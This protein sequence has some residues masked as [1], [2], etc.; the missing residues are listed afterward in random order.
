MGLLGFLKKQMCRAEKRQTENGDNL[1]GQSPISAE[2]YEAK[3]QAEED[4]WER[5]YDLSTVAGINAIPIPKEKVDSSGTGSVT[6]QIDYY[7][8]MKA[9]R[10]QST[11]E[12]ELALAC[13]RKAN[14]LMPMCAV[15][16]Y[17]KDR[18]MRLP[19]YLRKL[20]RFDEARFEEA[21]IEAM[22]PNGSEMSLADQM[23]NKKNLEN[24][25]QGTDLV[26]V[27]WVDGCCE[28][29]GKY[30]GRIF[31][32]TGADTRFP[33]FPNDFCEKCGLSYFPFFEG[34]SEP[35]YCKKRGAALIREMNKPFVDTR[36]PEDVREYREVLARIKSKESTRK[37]S[38]DYDWLWEF[39]PDLC[40]KSLSGYVRIK[41]A[42]SEKYKILVKE[43][44]K[45]G[46]NIC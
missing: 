41:N 32:A 33:R 12:V 35:L 11:G 42:N 2:K 21:K 9:G 26:E 20:R 19:R 36:T 15:S 18:Y 8:M 6:G 13:Y 31:S 17:S 46:R 39:L 23:E 5:K 14:A 43:A 38:A 25:M 22:F 29:C 10:Y 24:L 44:K 40:P 37:N 3:R 28:V 45:L 7:L 1:W 4:Y 27:T 30:R 34:F 16:S